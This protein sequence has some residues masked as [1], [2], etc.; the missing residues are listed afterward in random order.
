MLQKTYLKKKKNILDF[1]F[2]WYTHTLSL[3]FAQ[4]CEDK[5][6]NSSMFQKIG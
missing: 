4:K 5:T 2:W 6:A 1:L 3:W